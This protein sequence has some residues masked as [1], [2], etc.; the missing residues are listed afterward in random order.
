MALAS[1]YVTEP[2]RV[3]LQFALEEPPERW[4]LEEGKV[5][6][7]PLHDRTIALL[8]A[9]LEHWI[10][11]RCVR[12]RDRPAMAARNLGCRWDPD[13]ARVGTD[14]DIVLLEPPPPEAEALTTL[15][16]W[17][18]GHAPPPLAVE[19]VSKNTADEDYVEAAA[20]C[21]RLG[22]RELWVFDPLREGPATTGGPFVLQVWR[23]RDDVMA[24]VYA[25]AGPAF[26]EE[27]S[28][29]LVVTDQ[30]RRLRLAD[31]PDGVSLWPTSAEAAEA[32]VERLRR[33]LIEGR[34]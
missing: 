26:S 34:G 7:T 11:Q 22:V 5:P 1:E 19:V 21:A 6:E 29:W 23:R 28:A 18:P 20:R 13:D 10:L 25:G 32:E 16:V 4:R 3:G 9:I 30:G 31:D 17:E 12:E 27:L 8:M 33:A 2:A 14:P 24:R 15:R